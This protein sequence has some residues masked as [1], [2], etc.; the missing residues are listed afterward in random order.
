M[1]GDI[2][3][4]GSSVTFRIAAYDPNGDA[5][6][7]IEL[8]RGQAGG[9]IPSAAYQTSSG[10][11]SFSFTESLTSG[12]YWYFA[13]VVQA[14][15][16]D[17]WSA[18]MWITYSGTTPA[19][20]S[21]AAAPASLS[22]NPGASGSSTLTL[23]SSGGYASA[24]SLSASGLPSGVTASFSPASVTPPAN[25]S[26]TSTLTLSASA[27]AA[28]GSSTITITGTGGSKTHTAT[29]SLTV[30]SSG[31]LATYDATLKAPKCAS[32]GSSCDSGASLLLGR[33]TLG[34]EPNQPN[35]AGGSCA[36]GTSGTFH[37]DES[38]DRLK[39]STVDGTPFAAGKQVKVEATVW[40][41][42]SP[43][44]DKLDLYYA[45]NASSPTWT[46]LTTLTPAAGGAQTLSATY[47]LPA[48]AL[49]AVRAS[50][51]YN[52]SAAACSTGSYDDH[53]DLVFAVGA[54]A[55]DT[56][57]PSTSITAPAAGATVSASTTISA[58]ASDNVAVTNVE[59]YVD[60]A[61]K[62]S[63]STSPYSYPWD[64]TTAANG[65]HSLTTKA[66][67]AAGNVGPSS[68]VNVTVSNGS[69]PVTVFSDNAESAT[70]TFVK[71]SS[72]TG[73]QWTRITTSPYAGSYAW[74]AGSSTGG[75]YGNSGNATLTTPVLNLSGAT[76]ASLGYAFKY[77]TEANYDY[78]KVRISTDGGSTWTNLVNVSGTS[79]G[80]S[81]WAPPGNI[82]LNSYVGQTNVKVQFQ[83][84]SDG[85]VTGYGV[86]LD[87]VSITKQ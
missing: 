34:P 1:M 5:V 61:L 28:P 18:P 73:S 78:F 12:S 86:A 83:F 24:T 41:Y 87:N 71:A 67:D 50:F 9:G 49:Q 81:A 79:S 60:G 43:A 21:I 6:S 19:D 72:N 52:G 63:D 51:R 4:A 74:K 85:S 68:A 8:W 17:L 39:V 29:L 80:Y 64:T 44:S 37:S 40:A 14:D 70:T 20:F 62:G 32:I 22:L 13:H 10:S 76:T 69:V 46:F 47:T 30:N 3:S 48:G 38:N 66:Y 33:A 84:T 31:G 27:S 53:D 57:P 15:G 65:G 45:A 75:N 56:T 36:D 58:S 42:S 23:T 54:G 59:F 25:G 55:G 2:Y 77:S 26:A 11:A 16:H 35:T 7:T 82:S